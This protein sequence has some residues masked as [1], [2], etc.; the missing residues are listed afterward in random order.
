MSAGGENPTGPDDVRVEQEVDPTERDVDVAWELF[1]AQPTHPEIGRLATRVLAQQP[2][3]NGIRIL[4]AMHLKARDELDE[5][6][7]L[8]L[9]VVGQ[10]DRFF[11]DAARELRDLEQYAYR[12]QEARRW[13][14]VVLAEE[15]ESWLDVLALGVATAMAGDLEDG[16]QLLDDGVTLCAR[17]DADSLPHALTARTIYLMQSWA[18]A[19]RFIPAAEEAIAADP[20]SEIVGGPLAWA[21][22][23]A[24]RFEDAEELTLRMLRLDPTDGMAASVLTVLR[25]WQAVVERGDVSLA[26]IHAAGVVEWVW[27]QKRDELLG[28]DLASALAALEDV[29]P[30]ELR[31][32]LRP[33]LE[34]AAARESAGEREIAAWH[35]GQEPGTGAL[36]G[37]DRAFRLMSS[38]EIAAMDEQIEAEPEAHAQWVQSTTTDYYSQVMTDDEGSYLIVTMDGLRMRRTGA[39][40]VLVA[41]NLSAW[42]WERVAAFGGRSPI[43]L[44]RHD[45]ATRS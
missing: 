19:E 15:Q 4:L 6:R 9:S 1:D 27:G 43:P 34:E 2:G 31:A 20:S 7:E 5:A 35:D 13:A 16:W 26:D 22:M 17:T 38:T 18:P 32:A 45:A 30:A 11:V 24:G 28:T 21:Y 25:E 14:D 37:L 41:P 12:Y 8:L 42:F 39:D 29:M 23:R 44:A 36:W 3:R 10:R 40:D 33:P